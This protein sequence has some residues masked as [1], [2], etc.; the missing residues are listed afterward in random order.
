MVVDGDVL[1][2]SILLPFSI[3]RYPALFAG[4]PIVTRYGDM[5]SARVGRSLVQVNKSIYKSGYICL[6][7]VIYFYSIFRP[8]DVNI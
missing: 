6:G 3:Y 5:F 2:L 1:Q 4:V 7:V 8:Q